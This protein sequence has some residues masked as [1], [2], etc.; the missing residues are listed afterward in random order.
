M[1]DNILKFLKQCNLIK[2]SE[3]ELEGLIIL[4][5]SL[6]S[7]QKYD[8]IK[9]HIIELKKIH[10]SSAL[11]S[12]QST[13]LKNQKWP[14]LNLIRQILRV[15][16]YTMAPQRQSNG[17]SDGGRK[18]YIRYFI[19]EYEPDSNVD[20]HLDHLNILSDSES[21]DSSL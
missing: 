6:I 19:I 5:D 9:N 7:T 4:R 12:L 14:L 3:Q 1:D 15:N 20:K 2:N 16:G 11:T 10:S 17:Y 18:K 13:A 8:D 21:Q